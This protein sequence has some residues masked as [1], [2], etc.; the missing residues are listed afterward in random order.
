VGLEAG[1]VVG[2]GVISLGS[3][4]TGKGVGAVGR[5]SGATS[6]GRGTN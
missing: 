3:W 6:V 1:A 2:T 5:R 4:S